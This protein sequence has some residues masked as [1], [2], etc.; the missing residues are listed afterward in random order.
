[1]EIK[2]F[3]KCA[4]YGV[5]GLVVFNALST[6]SRFKEIPEDKK[7]AICFKTIIKKAEAK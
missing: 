1:M 2:D 5:L 7:I 4:S 3:K 6:F